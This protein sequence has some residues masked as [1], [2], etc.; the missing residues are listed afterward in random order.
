MTNH[1][2]FIFALSFSILKKIAT[3]KE[4]KMAILILISLVSTACLIEEVEQ[5]TQ[6]NAGETFTTMVTVSNACAEAST[7]HLGAMAVMVPDDWTY[8]S[9]SY[10]TTDDVGSGTMLVD[11]DNGS[12]WCNTAEG[13]VDIGTA[14]TTPDNMQ[15]VY[16]LSDVGS[17]TDAGVVH[18][19]TLTFGVGTTNGSYPIG[20]VATVNSGNMMEY[21]NTNDADDGVYC[22]AGL[23]TSFNHM[24]EVVGDT[25]PPDGIFIEG[26]VRDFNGDPIEGVDL[27]AESG[28]FYNNAIT[29]ENGYYHMELSSDLAGLYHVQV[30]GGDYWEDMTMVEVWEGGTQYDFM[31]GHR[32]ETALLEIQTMF[33]DNGDP[34]PYAELQSPQ[35]PQGGNFTMSVADWNGWDL[36][37]VL[38]IPSV[39][40]FGWH[41]E[42]GNG[43]G[44]TDVNTEINPGESYSVDVIFGDDPTDTGWLIVHVFDLDGNPINGAQVN[45]WGDV[46][47]F[48]SMT[49][50]QGHTIM[51]LPPGWY[52]VDAH[53]DGFEPGNGGSVEM[54]SNEE[55]SMDFML[56]PDNGGG[57]DFEFLGELNGHE[58][59]VS[60]FEST[61]NDAMYNSSNF[62]PEA[63]LVTI[64]SQEENDWIFWRTGGGVWIGFTDQYDEG[65]WEWVTG[66]DV[67]YTN[68]DEGEPNNDGEQHWAY[69]FETGQ[70]D[71]LN[72]GPMR[73]VYEIGETQ[74]F[75]LTNFEI[76][77]NGGDVAD[78]EA[79]E[80]ATV[81]I[82]FDDT[83]AEPYAGMLALFYDANFNDD[84][85]PEDDINFFEEDGEGPAVLLVDNMEP[86]ENPEIGI[87]ELTLGAQEDDGPGFLTLFQNSSWHFAS[88]NPENDEFGESIAT[89]N[90]NGF[91]SDYSIS[92]ATDP[93]TENMMVFAILADSAG[94][95]WDTEPH[96][97]LTQE[98][99][100][101]HV[102]V[103]DTGFYLIAMEDGLEIYG[104]LYASPSFQ[105]VEVSGHEARID[106]DIVEYDALVSGR[107]TNPE[108]EGIWDAE[109][110]FSY[111]N[112]DENVHIE[113]DTWTDDDGYYE[114]WLQEGYE[115]DVHVWADGY[116][117][118]HNDNVYIEGGG[119]EYNVTLEPWNN[120]WGAIEGT[121]K[122]QDGNGIEGALVSASNNF[123][124]SW[125]IHTDPGG[126]Y[127]LDQ[128]PPGYYEMEVSAEGYS[129]E[130]NTVE[131]Q[132]NETTIID[133]WLNWEQDMT[134]IY[135]Q[136]TNVV[137]E[138]LEMVKI[139]AHRLSGGHHNTFTN[140]EGYYDMD[141][142]E[143]GYNFSVRR[144]GYWVTWSDSIYVSGDEME[145]NWTMEPVDQFDGAWEGNINLEGEYEP[146]SI[147]LSIYNPTYEVVRILEGP[148]FQNV[149]L[150]NGSYS[151]RVDAEG[152]Q[153]VLWSDA[154]H[155]DNNVVNFDITLFEPGLVFPPHIEYA[156]DVPNDQG[157]QMR[158]VW[159]AGMPGDWSY[160]EFYSIWRQVNEASVDLWDFIEVVPWH[161]LEPYSA[162]V[163]TL[164]DSTDMGIYWSTFRVTG[165]TDD[166]NVFYD[167]EP[168]T[169]Y[170]VDNLHP[171]APGGVQ[172]FTGGDGILLTWD[173]PMDE[174]F[175]YHRI[176]RHDTDS[177]DPA[178]EFTTVDTFYVDDVAEGNY[179]YWI[180]AV[181]LNGNESDPSIIVTVTLAIDNGLAVPMEFALQQ[182]YPNPFNPSTQIQYALSTDANVS[183]A[184]YDLVGRKIRTLVNEQ[185]NA[186]YHSTLWN[187]TNEMGAPVS[188]GVYIY[189]ITANDFR[190][191]KKMILLK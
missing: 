21:I 116:M 7:P 127:Y 82:E 90:V 170:S 31:L 53:A 12:V 138:Q 54:F 141:L 151:L 13:A 57:D 115:Y 55:T 97:T 42:F 8:A 125:S 94:N 112:D 46:A 69:M 70:W 59:Y 62:D 98:D 111:H 5:P 66:E 74:D 96:M 52:E 27:H 142:P 28:D 176:Y 23:D 38:P 83:G 145:L 71:D 33:E 68:W 29:D 128:V 50:E 39:E 84:L 132:A 41:P 121:V 15:W 104:N 119:F 105:L 187:A 3:L 171:G 185:V 4:T 22:S 103:A 147:Y 161:G 109:V 189:T 186:G 48:N 168:I 113:S 159:N 75:E 172:A 149:P 110:N 81:T 92:G 120:E 79:G 173:S 108:G 34:V 24:V 131:V 78:I 135:G 43:Y 1:I 123:G 64:S 183:I 25:P 148:G 164:G 56:E 114:L 80:S 45:A 181:D 86:D 14:F 85:D 153:G 65:N 175:G 163:P 167:S 179:E 160:F 139:V 190:D 19:V 150:V 188:A 191:V 165:H 20:Y 184:I 36:I 26:I 87:I 100:S 32:E 60:N 162:V 35:S 93:S 180:T 95:D 182:N 101:Y 47:Y 154:I 133:F 11:P 18:E 136:V 37:T 106:F 177:G 122:D 10:T 72:D 44:S 58:Y 118:H 143:D 178:I 76:T 152:Y 140:G 67:D 61:W 156:G 16:L 107:V 129:T 6:V 30:Q 169:G 166:P 89:L 77:I 63:H 137:G 144:E 117:E 134:H 49:D 157:R 126:H 99:G 91:E 174:D 51:E 9:G 102:A 2:A 155:I 88:Y 124:S 17:L 130:W 158:L 40:V 73:F 146:E